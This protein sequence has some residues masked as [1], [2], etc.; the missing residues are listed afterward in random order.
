MQLCATPAT[1]TTNRKQQHPNDM[2]CHEQKATTM[3]NNRND[4]DDWK[5]E[6]QTTQ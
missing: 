6:T 4:N 1:T 5:R 3:K 2:N